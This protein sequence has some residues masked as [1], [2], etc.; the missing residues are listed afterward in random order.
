SDEGVA[1]LVI[2]LP[3]RRQPQ[4]PRVADD[5]L[6]AEPPLELRDDVAGRRLREVIGRRRLREAPATRDVTEHFEG[7]KLHDGNNIIRFVHVNSVLHEIV[8]LSIAAVPQAKLP[9]SR[10]GE[11]GNFA[12]VHAPEWARASC[13][14]RPICDDGAVATG[15]LTMS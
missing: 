8:S 3:Q 12:Y 14:R 11:A 4:R 1:A 7:F 9:A 5:E 15:S 2:L 10:R 13:T 6:D